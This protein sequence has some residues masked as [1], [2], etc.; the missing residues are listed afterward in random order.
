MHAICDAILACF[1]LLIY[2]IH[3]GYA[4]VAA[5]Q[6]PVVT[7]APGLQRQQGTPAATAI[8]TAANCTLLYAA[9]HWSWQQ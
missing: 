1:Y 2:R 9:E 3:H 6:M 5:T 4:Q 8:H 7:M